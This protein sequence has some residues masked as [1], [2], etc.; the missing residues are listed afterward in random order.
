MSVRLL[1]MFRSH[2]SSTIA[3]KSLC[4]GNTEGYPAV[5]YL[6]KL[7]SG[8]TR[9]MCEICSIATVKTPGQRQ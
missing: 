1:K 7:N 6:F 8:N 2:F 5:V 4:K 9:T 3:C